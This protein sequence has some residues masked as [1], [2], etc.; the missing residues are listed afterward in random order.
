MT[1]PLLE[2]LLRLGAAFLMGIGVGLERE[3]RQRMAGTRAN[4]LAAAGAAPFVI[5]L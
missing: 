4:A 3:W 1:T 2:F 5:A